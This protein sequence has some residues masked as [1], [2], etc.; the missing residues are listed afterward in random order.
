MPFLSRLFHYGVDLALVSTCVAGIR[1]SSG[2]S[3]EVEK[4]HNEDVKTAVEKYLNFGEWAFD[5]SSAFLGSSTW[6]KKV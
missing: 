4:I 1:R 3:F 6:F 2:I 5:Q